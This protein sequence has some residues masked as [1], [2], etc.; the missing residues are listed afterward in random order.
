MGLGYADV[1]TQTNTEI[2][3]KTTDFHETLYVSAVNT[4]IIQDVE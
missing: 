1:H 3:K 2:K 4:G